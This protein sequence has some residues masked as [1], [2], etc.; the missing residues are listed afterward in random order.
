MA[1]ALGDAIAKLALY[2]PPCGTGDLDIARDEFARYR[3]AMNERVEANRR[4]AA[5]ALL[6][7]D[8]VPPDA[9]KELRQSPEWQRMAACPYARLRQRRHG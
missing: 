8:M 6:L 2:E 5:V 3:K 7:E 9:P 1:A 4:D